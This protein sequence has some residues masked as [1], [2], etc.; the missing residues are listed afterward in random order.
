MDLASLQTDMINQIGYAP[1]LADIYPG[2]ELRFDTAKPKRGDGW[3]KVFEDCEG[4]V[5]E[6]HSRPG[7]HT[8][9]LHKKRTP[10]E[11]A[12]FLKQVA[13]EK[14][15]RRKRSEQKQA[16]AE[17]IAQSVSKSS[18]QAK[19]DH[20]YLLRKRC[21]TV[22]TLREI[23]IEKLVEL[24]GYHPAM[25]NERLSG[26]ILVAPV[27]VR[28]KFTTIEMIDENGL[29]SALAGGVKSGG[30][31]ATCRLPENDG[32]KVV[33]QL[34]EGV[35]TAL[36]CYKANG[37]PT[38]AVLSCGNFMKV[39]KH[40]RSLYPKA[41]IIVLSDLGNGQKDAAAAAADIGGCL[42]IPKFSNPDST[43]SDF[44]DVHAEEGIDTVFDQISAAISTVTPPAEFPQI[45][46]E[47]E[48]AR[49][50]AKLYRDRMC[51]DRDLDRYRIWNGSVWSRGVKGGEFNAVR[52]YVDQALLHAFDSPNREEL[53]KQVMRLHAHSKQ[54]SLLASISVTPEIIVTSDEFDSDPLLLNCPNGT[55]DLRTGKLQRHSP[56]DRITLSIMTPYDAA[57]E[58]PVFLAF[59]D[60][61][62]GGNQALTGYLQRL[63]GYFLTGSIKEQVF[64][65]WIGV[66]C[67]GKSTLGNV[68]LEL[69]G[70]YG[71]TAGGELLLQRQNQ[72]LSVLSSLASLRGKRFALVSELDDGERLSEA[73]VKSI[74]GGDPITAKYYHR[75]PFSYF[76]QFKPVL[77]GNHRPVIRG[78]DPG[79]WRR[80]HLLLFG[81]IIPP[82]EKDLDLPDKLSK[83][84]PGILSWAVQGCL[85]WQKQGLNPPMEVLS[86][87]AEYRKGENVFQQWLDECC[88][89]SHHATTSSK[90]LLDSYTE[91]SGN[92][93]YSNIKLGKA[94]KEQGFVSR[95][96][97]RGRK[98]W[99]G[100]GVRTTEGTEG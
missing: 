70:E 60:R 93:N 8:W 80:I 91:F 65:V 79:I 46:S 85:Q 74:T 78:T 3:L 32:D 19:A 45:F 84:L 27:K 25:H 21:I 97:S 38:V 55:I 82:E 42:A 52:E 88:I 40:I 87:T 44:N 63:I 29:K 20:P 77:L 59:I 51:F 73:R 11:N 13:K 28:D 17:Q 7:V 1:E 83:E 15:I 90:D 92:K 89:E 95:Q 22:P 5:Y 26:R 61:I 37:N 41:K 48:L 86:A 68:L 16:K 76:P 96:D 18:E 2:K 64:S 69:L 50:F 49:H 67:N 39:A 9:Q 53:V 58:C 43:G 4:A 14:E 23:N 24:I 81:V 98:V 36:S 71:G 99:D 57:A 100:I 35:S 31:W 10:E 62:M 94:L 72:D 6:D 30:Y 75:D 34:A 33:I 12:D 66:G 54:V 47:M 56:A